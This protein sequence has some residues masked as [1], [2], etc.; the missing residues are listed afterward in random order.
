[1]FIKGK[2]V[3]TSSRTTDLI[4]GIVAPKYVNH[5]RKNTPKEIQEDVKRELGVDIK[6]MKAYLGTC[7]YW[8]VCIQT[9][10]SKCI[11]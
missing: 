6:Y 8:I 1:M 11:I 9:L 2:S 4:S 5:K 7:I 10:T 3:L